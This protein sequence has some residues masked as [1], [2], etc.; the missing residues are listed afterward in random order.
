MLTREM[1]AWLFEHATRNKAVAVVEGVM[2][3]FD[4]FDGKSE[5]GSTAEI[6][7]WLGLPVILVIDAYA[8]ARSAEAL[9]LG[10]QTFDPEVKIA[11]VIFNRVAGE[12]H[13][14]ILADA[15]RSV[16]ILLAAGRSGD[17]IPERHLDY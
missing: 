12:G 3:L 13:Y 15:V 6:A 16:P 9:I 10:F 7:K 17:Q 1:N 2:G 5:R 14:R 8:M 4:G 11:G